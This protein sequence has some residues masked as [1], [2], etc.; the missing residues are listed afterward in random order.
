MLDVVIVAVVVLML[1]TM[2]LRANRRLH[3]EPSLP[4]QWGLNG[5]VNWSAPRRIALA[6]TPLLAIICLSAALV[7]DIVSPS[8][9]ATFA[10]AVMAVMFVAVHALHLWLINRWQRTGGR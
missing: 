2:S 1:S 7:S 3:G 9:E 4:M 8:D 5:D 10:I 6:F